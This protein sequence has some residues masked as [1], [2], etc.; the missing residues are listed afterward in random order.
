VDMLP[1]AALHTSV[2]GSYTSALAKPQY[3]VWEIYPMMA[4]HVDQ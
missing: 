3:A 1:V 2:A 4:L